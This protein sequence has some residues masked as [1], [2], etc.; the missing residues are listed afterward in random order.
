MTNQ[1]SIYILNCQSNVVYANTIE[2]STVAV[3]LM[4]YSKAG[5][6]TP[7]NNYFYLNSFINNSR[8]FSL[9]DLDVPPPVL[10]Q[11][12]DVTGYFNY[13]SYSSYG[14][15]WSDYTTKYPNTTVIGNT[16]I[17]DTPYNIALNNTDYYPLVRPL[18]IELTLPSISGP[19]P[20]QSPSATLIPS[21][22]MQPA[23]QTPSSTQNPQPTQSTPTPTVPESSWCVIVPLLL[24]TLSVAVILRHRKTTKPL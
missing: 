12:N 18:S 24:S 19:P 3:N 20:T 13:W 17:G 21:S 22:T 9:M 2:N 8:Q 7:S 5:Y 11:T 16:G 14:N 23:P 1:Y 6:S 4:E 10:G 15:Y